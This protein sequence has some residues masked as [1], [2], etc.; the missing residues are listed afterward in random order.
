MEMMGEERE[1]PRYGMINVGDIGPWVSWLVTGTASEGM[2]AWLERRRDERRECSDGRPE[3][4]GTGMINAVAVGCDGGSSGLDGQMRSGGVLV[5]CCCCSSCCSCNWFG[6]GRGTCC[7]ACGSCVPSASC[8]AGGESS[9]SDD[10]LRPNAAHT[11]SSSACS[12]SRTLA[13]AS[14]A[15]LS[16][17]SSI[18]V[19][20]S[21]LQDELLLLLLLSLLS[22]S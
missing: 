3:E 17:F 22:G 14:L 16:S 15:C 20:Q 21:E 5:C 7:C 1:G 12:V 19:E 2:S 10:E 9:S 13:A 18:V 6:S 8:A 4:G 11:S